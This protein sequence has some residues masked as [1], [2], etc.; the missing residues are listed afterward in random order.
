MCLSQRAVGATSAGVQAN[1]D[2]DPV[3]PLPAFFSGPLCDG[4]PLEFI[5]ACPSK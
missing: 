2:D 3:R 5:A 4:V 1:Y